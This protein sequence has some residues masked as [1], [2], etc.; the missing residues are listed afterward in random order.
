MGCCTVMYIFPYL[1]TYIDYSVSVGELDSCRQVTFGLAPHVLLSRTFNIS[2]VNELLLCDRC[3]MII[4][5][6]ITKQKRRKT[7]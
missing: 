5:R 1:L 4:E 6:Y 2:L 3:T 7:N